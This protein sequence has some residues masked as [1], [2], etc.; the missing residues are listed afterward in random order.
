MDTR[1]TLLMSLQQE[2][3]GDEGEQQQ[4]GW[5]GAEGT[6]QASKRWWQGGDE[7]GGLGVGK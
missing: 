5:E 1:D 3:Q 7:T 4:T 6:G 2:R